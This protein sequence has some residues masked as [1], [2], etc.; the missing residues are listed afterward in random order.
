MARVGCRGGSPSAC[1][2]GVL[3]VSTQ[4][5]L[6][7]LLEAAEDAGRVAQ[8]QWIPL[9]LSLVEVGSQLER[10]WNIP[11]EKRE[12][13]AVSAVSHSVSQIYSC[14]LGHR[15]VGFASTRGSP[16]QLLPSS[17]GG[18]SV[19]W[20]KCQARSQGRTW[21]SL[22]PKHGAEGT[23]CPCLAS[24]KEA[25]GAAQC[26]IS[27][28]MGLLFLRQEELMWVFFCPKL[29]QGSFTEVRVKCQQVLWEWAA[30]EG[31]WDTL[32]FLG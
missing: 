31:Q 18:G 22:P 17:T 26:S 7:L 2:V 9:A 13:V 4:G 1:S 15:A 24:T 29:A 20:W 21:G 28:A 19:C 10:G 8:Q 12:E 23:K 5:C 14:Y 32:T 16:S 3:W 25:V 11:R 30:C 27:M 6:A